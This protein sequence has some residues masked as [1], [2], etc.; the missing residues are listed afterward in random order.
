[1]AV[2]RATHIRRQALAKSCRLLHWSFSIYGAGL[3]V[4]W[5]PGFPPAFEAAALFHI[6][7]L[8]AVSVMFAA[9]V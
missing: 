4:S 3:L 9:Q 5:L 8:A 2:C 7:L 1:V 6:F